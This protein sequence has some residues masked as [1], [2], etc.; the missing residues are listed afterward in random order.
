[1]SL[2][3]A[4]ESHAHFRDLCVT[5]RARL[6]TRCSVLLLVAWCPPPSSLLPWWMAGGHCASLSRERIASAT[7]SLA[8]PHAA[9]R[10]RPRGMPYLPLRLCELAGSGQVHAHT[11]GGG[12][13]GSGGGDAGRDGGGSRTCTSSRAAR[14]PTPHTLGS[15]RTWVDGRLIGRSLKAHRALIGRSS[16]AHRA[17]IEG[18]SGAH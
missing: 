13:G 5:H 11:G 3:C 4:T 17:L 1:M 9:A 15:R 7:P 2:E 12:G 14:L 16:G 6:P 18:S 10:P 8:P